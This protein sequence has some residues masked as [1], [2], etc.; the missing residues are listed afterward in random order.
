[1]ENLHNGKT[2]GLERTHEP[3]GVSSA[4]YFLASVSL[5]PVAQAVHSGDWSGLAVLGAS[6]GGAVSTNLLANIVQKS[7]DK[8]DAEVAQLLQEEAKSSPELQAEI[9]V[10][11]QKLDALN[12]AEKALSQAD[13]A[14]FAELIQ[15]ELK[16]LNSG[17]KYEAKVIGDGAIAQGPNSTAVG[18]GGMYIGGNVNNATIMQGDNARKIDAKTYVEHQVVYT[19]N[20]EAEKK[21]KAREKY[22]NHLSRVCLSLPLVALGGVDG[23]ES[24]ITLDKIYI[25]LN[26]TEQRQRDEEVLDDEAIQEYREK[27]E[28]RTVEELIP[29]LESVTKHK[30]LALLG[31]P[32]AGKSTFVKNLLAWQAGL[33][34]GKIQDSN[35]I[36]A[37]L[38]PTLIILRYLTPRLAKLEIDSLPADQRDAKLAQILWDHMQA[39]LG[40]ECADFREGLSEALRSGKCLLVLDGLD[41]VPH[42]LR[43]RVRQAVD[44][45][46]KQYHLQRAIITCRVRSYVGETILPSFESRTLAPFDEDQIKN[47]VEHWYTT[48]RTLGKFNEE[49]AKDRMNDSQA[50]KSHVFMLS[51]S[52]VRFCRP[53]LTS[54]LRRWVLTVS[55]EMLN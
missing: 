49:Q 26:T 16:Q 6:L 12:E 35:G 55:G 47:F 10:V 31:D 23:D 5:L 7:K 34:L 8:S 29:A 38:L 51:R 3:A 14:W 25:A 33:L 45:L 43:L 42:D 4:Y 54:T 52:S 21:A 41:E 40:D 30:K 36:E 17:I 2:T 22:L 20:P 28:F 9:E 50:L 32:G 27:R 13:K 24:D 48:Q 1:M 11:L 15:R 37:D 44:A 53:N 18:A 39:D 19:P 46:F